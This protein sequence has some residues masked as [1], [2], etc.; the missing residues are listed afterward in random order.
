MD[1][2][3]EEI[4]GPPPKPGPNR[5]DP[6]YELEIS[7]EEMGEELG[8]M[9][10]WPGGPRCHMSVGSCA[11]ILKRTGRPDRLETLVEDLRSRGGLE[12]LGDGADTL[13]W[14]AGTA[15]TAF[16]YLQAHGATFDF[17]RDEAVFPDGKV[18]DHPHAT[19][20]MVGAAWEEMEVGVSYS[21]ETTTTIRERL[22]GQLPSEELTHT[23]IKRRLQRY[24]KERS[25]E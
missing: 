18:G 23:K 9:R 11:A 2:D 5:P 6:P 7:V 15:R 8:A 4:I 21:K 12:L 14:L 10:L 1:K 24:I 19:T 3:P 13:H 16:D 22:E 17:E 20:Y 25:A